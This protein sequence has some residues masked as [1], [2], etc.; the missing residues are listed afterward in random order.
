MPMRSIAL[1]SAAIG[2]GAQQHAA[3][4]FAIATSRPLHVAATGPTA[5]ASPLSMAPAGMGMATKPKGK[6]KNKKN[7]KNGGKGMGTTSPDKFDV[8]KAAIKSEKLYDELMSESI[9]ALTSDEWDESEVDV[10]TEYIVAARRRPGAASTKSAN[11]GACASSS[12]WIPVAQI[13]V[14]RPV[15]ADEE[16]EHERIA[17]TVRAAVSHYRREINYAASL[18]APSAFKSLPRNVVEYSAE[19]T[20]SF[21]KY[22]YE[23]VIEG[24][25]GESFVEGDAKVGMTKSKAREVLGLEAGCKDAA[26]IKRAYKLKSMESHPDRFAGSDRTKEDIDRSSE[27]FALVKMAYE[28]LNSGVREV[29]GNGAARSWTEF[30]GPIELMSA[31]EAGALCGKAF[32]SAVVGLDPDLT[33]AFVARNQ[34]AAR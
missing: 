5:P 28:A 34:A 26:I 30:V 12:D 18:A 7:S 22:V 11:G 27:R 25:A 20:D 15:R 31:D 23:D 29:D 1:A 21:M 6:K 33:M 19:P 2:I 3:N 32:K 13:V 8:A 4:A 9:K 14:V 17:S 10:T 16:D 24:K